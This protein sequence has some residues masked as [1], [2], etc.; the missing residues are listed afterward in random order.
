MSLALFTICLISQMH[1]SEAVGGQCKTSERSVPGN[2]TLEGIN[3][4]KTI[5]EDLDNIIQDF[6]TVRL[7]L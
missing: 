1:G 6:I 3:C 5:I 2:L 4:Y 7:G